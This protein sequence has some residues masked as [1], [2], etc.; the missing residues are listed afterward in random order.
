MA[1]ASAMNK[2]LAAKKDQLAVARASRVPA[3]H[4]ETG[5]HLGYRSPFEMRDFR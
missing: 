5:A 3:L 2:K 1:A 4:P